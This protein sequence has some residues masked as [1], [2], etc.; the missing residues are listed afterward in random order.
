VILPHLL[1]LLNK[2]F[3]EVKF[4]K[5]LNFLNQ[6]VISSF[7]S[8]VFTIYQHILLATSHLS[9]QMTNKCQQ[10]HKVHAENKINKSGD[11]IY[12]CETSMTF[13]A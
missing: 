13:R 8:T 7:N 1:L 10:E 11:N 6:S 3:D 4:N 9:P 2:L 12:G 5:I